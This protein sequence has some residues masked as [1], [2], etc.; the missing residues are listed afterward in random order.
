MSTDIQ[1]DEIDLAELFATLWAG[2]H[3]I[4]AFCAATILAAS[5]FLHTA[6]RKYTASVTLQPITSDQSVPNLGGLG[7]LASLAGVSLPSGGA[8]DFGTFEALLTSEEVAARVINRAP[9]IQK[10]YASEWNADDG[11]YM[12]NVPGPAS[13]VLRAIKYVLT[14]N[15]AGDYTPPNGQRLAE[16]VSKTL[17]LSTNRDTGFLTISAEVSDPQLHV[18]LMLAVVEEADALL[19]ERFMATGASTLAF[20]QNKILS[21]R[22]REHREALAKLIAQEE[23][24]LMLATRDTAYVADVVMG[25]N[26]SLK[27]TSPKASLVLALAFVLGLFS[28]AAAVLIRSAIKNRQE[29]A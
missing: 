16:Y 24:K 9:L 19:K 18:E 7:G 8:S 2:K 13:N 15:S 17:A 3:I 20:Y 11:K 25:P 6:D 27:P 14:G 12:P 10:I 5:V 23:Q 21:A 4:G 26:I 1:D 28:G 22:A 29:N